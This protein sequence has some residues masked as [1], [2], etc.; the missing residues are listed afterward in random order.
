MLSFFSIILLALVAC[1]FLAD[2]PLQGSYMAAAKNLNMPEG[3]GI[4]PIV[5]FGHAA[6]HGAFVVLCTGSIGFGLI[7]LISHFIIDL[8][9]CG[10]L[11]SFK[12]DQACHLALKLFFAIGTT[13][14]MFH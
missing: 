6:I 7:E 5:L 12:T 10:K 8:A 14:V 13:I 11:I 9:K 4:W 2:F 1:H 3:K